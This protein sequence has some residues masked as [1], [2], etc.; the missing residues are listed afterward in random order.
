MGKFNNIQ[1]MLQMT[2]GNKKDKSDEYKEIEK[3]YG[4]VFF[5]CAL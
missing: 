4:T 1:I 3:Q 2:C 5:K